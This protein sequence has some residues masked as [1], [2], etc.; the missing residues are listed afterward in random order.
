MAVVIFHAARDD[1][2]VGC[3]KRYGYVVC[4]K[5]EGKRIGNL[6]GQALL[7]LRSFGEVADDPGDF[8]EADYFCPGEVGDIGSTMHGNKVVLAKTCK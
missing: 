8:R 5:E 2:V 6:I 7:H 3:D 4:F 1:A